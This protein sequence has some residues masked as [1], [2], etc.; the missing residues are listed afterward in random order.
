M[1]RRRPRRSCLTT[2][3]CLTGDLK[4]N[5]LSIAG[6]RWHAETALGD[7]LRPHTG[8]SRPRSID[9]SRCDSSPAT[10]V[11]AFSMLSVAQGRHPLPRGEAPPHRSP[12]TSRAIVAVHCTSVYVTPDTLTLRQWQTVDA[13][14]KGKGQSLLG[15]LPAAASTPAAAPTSTL[16]SAK[17]PMPRL[18][19][20][21][22]VPRRASRL[23]PSKQA[24][25]Q[26]GQPSLAAPSHRF[27]ATSPN[28]S[29]PSS[30]SFPP[31]RKSS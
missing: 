21:R 18:P 3:T 6:W 29:P 23:P 24:D 20:S 2:V 27:R 28:G 4:W 16:S 13:Q 12:S 9:W 26:R 1:T 5:L 10:W 7:L 14:A 22:Y 31:V 19:V 30:A 15:R 8:E 25:E 11:R 17:S